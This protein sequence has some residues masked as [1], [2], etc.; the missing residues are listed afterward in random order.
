MVC[1]LKPN[2][3]GR[4][5]HSSTLPR[6]GCRGPALRS[7]WVRP[8]AGQA[9]AAGTGVVCAR[10][11]EHLFACVDP[12]RQL[13]R[14]V[15]RVRDL[16]VRRVRP[17]PSSRLSFSRR[18]FVKGGGI[19]RFSGLTVWDIPG[20][21]QPRRAS[22]TCPSIRIVAPWTQA[23]RRTCVWSVLDDAS[24]LLWSLLPAHGRP[25]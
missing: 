5:A 10:C 7:S 21:L 13:W 22:W 17:T 2:Y 6:S 19:T 16:R 3:R 9:G 4:C 1:T 15:L 23:D 20:P 11:A 14:L 8:Q 18:F 24:I 12:A 25:I